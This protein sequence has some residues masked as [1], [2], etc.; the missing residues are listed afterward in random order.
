ML[1]KDTSFNRFNGTDVVERLEG[2]IWST[3]RK[4]GKISFL[5][6]KNASAIGGVATSRQSSD[7]V[8]ATNIRYFKHHHFTLTV[9]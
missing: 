2:N 3:K 9:R 4:D 7:V 1:Y 6:E 5:R 8:V